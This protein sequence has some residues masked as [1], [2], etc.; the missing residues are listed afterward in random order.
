MTKDSPQNLDE[1]I[2]RIK[3]NA[4]ISDSKHKDLVD[5]A[6]RLSEMPKTAVPVANFE[7][8]KNQ[9]LDRITIPRQEKQTRFDLV[10]S[11]IPR[12]LRL[13][14]AIIGSFLILTSLAIG[15]A[16]A[17][18]QSLP[19]QPIYPLKQV[20]ERIELRFAKNDT[21]R[22]NL[23]LEFANNRLDELER[24]LEKNRKGQISEAEV[25]KVVQ[26]TVNNL[27][28]TTKTLTQASVQNQ[29]QPQV[30]I[31]NK[32][33]DLNNKQTNILQSASIQSEG[34]VKIELE[35]ALEVSKSTLDQTVTDIQRAGLKIEQPSIVISGQPL[36]EEPAADIVEASGKLTTVTASSVS[37][38]TAKFYLTKDTKFV[39]IIQSDLKVDLVVDIK[40]VIS[41]E[42]T[43]VTE[44]SA[45]KESVPQIPSTDTSN[46]IT[47]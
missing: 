4:P 39:N 1:L 21:D 19:G 43:L 16:V 14:G 11:Y 23:Q 46:T 5:I 34:I 28:E 31:L 27:T 18:L 30:Q 13:S 40:G 44:I 37:I 17:A 35:K 45:E 22:A 29:S 9:I 24:V 10:A 32:I 7:R 38:G 2:E 15:T 12:F 20:V 26:S 3:Q 25:S 8:V 47:L 41:D 6:V 42:R 36:S 33:V